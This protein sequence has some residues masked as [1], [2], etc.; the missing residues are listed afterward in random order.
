MGYC[1]EAPITCIEAFGDRIYGMSRWSEETYE[2]T[3]KQIGKVTHVAFAPGNTHMA[4]EDIFD[5]PEVNT[6]IKRMIH[7]DSQEAA[8]PLM[9]PGVGTPL[10]HRRS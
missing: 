8:L 6:D 7:M 2:V 5:G 4:A 1:K 3:P 9:F 10:S